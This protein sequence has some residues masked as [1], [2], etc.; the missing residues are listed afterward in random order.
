MA[1]RPSSPRSSRRPPAPR[2]VRRPTIDGTVSD[3]T[4]GSGSDGSDPGS[5][6]IGL[7]QMMARRG[8]SHGLILSESGIDAATAQMMDRRFS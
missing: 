7:A 6:D 3:P 5:G 8:M 1:R 4:G 2:S